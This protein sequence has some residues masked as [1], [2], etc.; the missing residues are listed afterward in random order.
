MRACWGASPLNKLSAVSAPT[1]DV[2]NQSNGIAATNTQ[3]HRNSVKIQQIIQ[4]IGCAIEPVSRNWRTPFELLQY[5]WPRRGW[6]V[7]ASII[8]R[9]FLHLCSRHFNFNQQI[10]KGGSM[11]QSTGPF[12]T[13][14]LATSTS[15]N[16]FEK[17][18]VC[19]SPC[20]NY[21][22]RKLKQRNSSNQNA[23]P[24]K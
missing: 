9:P 23:K 12:S 22:R 21:W 5:W 15:T 2:A 16:K 18:Q 1:N 20:S 8:N 7:D 17:G 11:S 10:S 24:A 6:I 19:R 13:S 3:S 14:A 4:L